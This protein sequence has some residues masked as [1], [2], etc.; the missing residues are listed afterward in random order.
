MIRAF[1]GARGFA[2]LM[3]ALFH[4][5]VALW[6]PAIRSGYLFVDLFFVLSGYLISSIYLHR[7]EERENVATFVVRRFGRLFPLLIF[8]TIVFVLFVNGVAFVK[9]LAVARGMATFSSGIAAV[10][11]LVPTVGEIAATL[12]MAHGL[13]VYDTPVL[14]WVSWSI[15]VEF[16]TYLLFAAT[17]LFLPRRVRIVAFGV[18]AVGGYLV[19]CWA[20][21][22]RHDCFVAG[23]CFDVTYDF[24]IARCI[25]AFFLGGLTWY[26]G[27]RLITVSERQREWLQWGALA[28]LAVVFTFADQVPLLTFTCPPLFAVLVYSLATDK[29][30]LARVLN[31]PVFQ[32]LGERSYSIYMMHPIVLTLIAPVQKKLPG[33]AAS[34]VLMCVYVLVTV[35]VAGYTYRLVEAPCRDYFNRVAGRLSIAGVRRAAGSKP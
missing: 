17:C 10:P 4:L 23:R 18:L 29:G 26:A 30:P 21:I 1:E 9:N 8:S 25:S 2:A 27:R 13:G 24:G 31:R 15:S 3:V 22:G 20:T 16:Y 14:N 11:Y 35:W 33:A 12:S 19:T 6:F 5:Q 32:L 7:L 28:A 34:G